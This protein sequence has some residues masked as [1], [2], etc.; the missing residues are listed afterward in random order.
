MRSDFFVECYLQGSAGA[1]KLAE[2]ACDRTAVG[3]AGVAGQLAGMYRPEDAGRIV[4][5][6]R[7]ASAADVANVADAL[8]GL[9]N[10]GVRQAWAVAAVTSAPGTMQ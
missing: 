10:E 5:R 9:R 6:L 4:L 1:V 2:L 8:A 7:Q 3:V